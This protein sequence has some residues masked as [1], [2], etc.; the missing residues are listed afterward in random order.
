[1]ISMLASNPRELLG[2]EL[3]VALGCIET[4]EQGSEF[5]NA[6]NDEQYLW[7]AKPHVSSTIGEHF[8]HL[9]DLFHAVYEAS[10]FV[11]L[12]SQSK[13]NHQP[14]IDYNFRRRGH[15]VEV[16][17]SQAIKE[18]TYFIQWLETIREDELKKTVSLLTEVSLLQTD[19]HL[20]T[21]TFERELTFAS[22]HA[23]HHFAMSKVTTSLMNL[24]VC[25]SFGYAPAT[26]T[27]LRGK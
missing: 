6:L 27:Y 4:L 11:N 22:L 19:T 9:L 18:L 26:L 10:T 3:P 7:S 24:D 2:R 21:S 12:A 8:R 14:T 16:S 13:K 25:E 23:N 20:M 15:D 1:M 17:R 5:L